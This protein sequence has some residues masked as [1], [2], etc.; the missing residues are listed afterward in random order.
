MLNATLL[1]RFISRDTTI[2]ATIV[3]PL[4]NPHVKYNSQKSAGQIKEWPKSRVTR[5]L[6]SMAGQMP[7]IILDSSIDLDFAEANLYH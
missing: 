3:G 2:I 1:H 7:N 5:I 6:H 4:T